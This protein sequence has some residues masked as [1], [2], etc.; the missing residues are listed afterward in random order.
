MEK[1]KMGR[2]FQDKVRKTLT[3]DRE[4]VEYLDSLPNGDRSRFANDILARGIA[5]LTS[6]DNLRNGIDEQT[7]VP[8]PMKGSRTQMNP[9]VFLVVKMATDRLS[10]HELV[11]LYMLVITPNSNIK[12]SYI[13]EKAQG[14][15][16]E[17][18]GSKMHPSTIEA[19]DVIIKQ[20]IQ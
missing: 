6:A 4:I 2:P 11:Q 15:F 8:N 20:R 19:L 9:H 5:E 12:G 13:Y 1:K 18:N 10:D 16:T 14:L 17:D 7:H 3:L